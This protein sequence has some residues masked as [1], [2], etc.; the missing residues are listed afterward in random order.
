MH[1][2]WVGESNQLKFHL[3]PFERTRFKALGLFPSI[4]LHL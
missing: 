4:E 1:L 2:S 3:N